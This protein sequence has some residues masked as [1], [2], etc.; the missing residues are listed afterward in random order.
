M[1]EKWYC[2]DSAACERHFNAHE[3]LCV[4][5]NQFRDRVKELEGALVK[6]Q[7]GS[8]DGCSN[9]S[10]YCPECKEH[11]P[12]TY[13]DGTTDYVGHTKECSVGRAL[14]PVTGGA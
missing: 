10:D 8:C 13:A 9:G 3:R 11:R 12:L 14:K 7:W 5:R 4:E 6:I 1:T 2:S